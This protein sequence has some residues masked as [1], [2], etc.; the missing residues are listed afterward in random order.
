MGILFVFFFQ[1][2]DVI[3]YVVRSRGLGDVYKRQPQELLHVVDEEGPGAVVPGREAD[4]GDRRGDGLLLRLER[5]H[6]DGSRGDAAHGDS[7]GL[8][9]HVAVDLNGVPLVGV[10]SL[11]HI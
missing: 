1:A 5:L 3:R 9:R 10:L 2:E 4:V 8:S 6:R 11:L 7:V